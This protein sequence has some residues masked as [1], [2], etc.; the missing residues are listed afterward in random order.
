MYL[1]FVYMKSVAGLRARE[2]IFQAAGELADDPLTDP[3]VV[4]RVDRLRIWFAD[5]LDLPGRF[6]KTSSKGYFDKDTKGLSWFKPS[7]RE[8]IARAFELKSILDEYGYAIEVLKTCRIGYV[9]YE[10]EH[11]IVAEPFADTIT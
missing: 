9:V 6:S 7:A 4:D 8:H 2:G 1:R 10:D 3:V 11:Q 5:N